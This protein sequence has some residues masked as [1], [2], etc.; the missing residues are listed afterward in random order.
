MPKRKLETKKCPYCSVVLGIN[1]TLC[2]SCKRKVGPSN[3][4]GIA[5]KPFDWKAYLMLIL[6]VG[7]F[8]WFTM[9]SFGKK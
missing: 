9:W 5:K 2:F 1:D 6:S 7:A 3:K 4:Y 8:I